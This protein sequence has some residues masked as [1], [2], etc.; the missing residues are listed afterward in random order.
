M[1]ESSNRRAFSGELYPRT[2]ARVTAKVAEV[3]RDHTVVKA[4]GEID[5]QSYQPLLELLTAQLHIGR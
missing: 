4:A 2:R 3:T 1:S 5:F